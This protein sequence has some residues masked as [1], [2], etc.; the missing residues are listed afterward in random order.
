MFFYLL[1]VPS[2]AIILVTMFELVH[3]Q[4]HDRILY[5][6][7]QLRRNILAFLRSD[8]LKLS[9]YEYQLTNKML[10]FVGIT[11]HDFNMFKKEVFNFRKAKK[12]L[13]ASVRAHHHKD[14]FVETENKNISRLQ[15]QFRYCIII[16]MFAYTP[17]IMSELAVRFIYSVGK[18]LA[19]AGLQRGK[20]ILTYADV[21]RGQKEW[22]K[23]PEN[24]YNLFD[25][26]AC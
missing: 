2:F 13:K 12:L 10:E 22:F 19:K 11:I 7:C 6:Y 18:V 25:H 14:I 5:S 4:K 8:G 20:N 21:F 23:K 24:H 16:S 1:I 17:F 3:I 15:N 26:N 9:E